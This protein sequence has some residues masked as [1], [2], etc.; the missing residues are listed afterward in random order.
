MAAMIEC[1][2][3]FSEGRDR[4]K[5]DRILDAIR[6]VS[7]VTLLDV[8]SDAD[9][10]R[11]V[12]TFVGGREVVGEAAVRGAAVAAQLIDLRHHRGEHPRMGA[13]DVIPFVPLEGASMDDCIALAREVGRRLGEELGIPVFLYESAASR[14]DRANLADVRRGEFEGLRDAIGTDPARTPDFG[15]ARIHDSAG[16]TAVGARTFLVAYNVNLATADLEVANRIARA[17]RHSSGGYRYVKAMGVELMAR[18]IVQVSMNLTDYTKTPVFRAF[19]AVRREAERY[20][21][22]VVGSEIVGLVP[23]EALER[24]AEWYLKVEGFKRGQVIEN[25]LREVATAAAEEADVSK[26]VERVAAKTPTPG[27]GSVAAL[28]GALGAALAT[29]G[30]RLTLG[31]AKYAEVE[32]AMRDIEQQAIAL[33]RQLLDLVERDARSFD[34]VLAAM[35]LPAATEAERASRD[36]AVRAATLEAARVPLETMKAAVAVL[37]LLEVTSRLANRNAA[38]DAAVGALIARA[39]VKGAGLNVDVNLKS[40]ASA[41]GDALLAEV[42]SLNASAADLEATILVNAGRP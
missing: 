31:K 7:G 25:R 15:P 3:N 16:A 2:P 37:T 28:A 27:G 20:G 24:T 4:G 35:R 5:L 38:T 22:Q 11:S 12:V 36:A 21:V 17:L 41:D 10:N 26:F 23:G 33:Q 6:G 29:M 9:H 1:V 30:A 13:T 14:P 8:E 34:G 18:G 19:E 40:L 32:P 39:A 42:A